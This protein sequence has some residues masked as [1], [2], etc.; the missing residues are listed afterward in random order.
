MSEKLQGA[1][2]TTRSVI[3]AIGPA[4]AREIETHP[5]VVKVCRSSKAKA[6]RLIERLHRLGSI[7]SDGA[8]QQARYW[9]SNAQASNYDIEK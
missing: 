1:I 2:D 4:T 7:K 8:P 3:S 5:D 9:V 6:R